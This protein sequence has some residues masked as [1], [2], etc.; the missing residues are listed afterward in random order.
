MQDD[1]VALMPGGKIYATENGCFAKTFGLNERDEPTIYHAVTSPHAYLEN[2]SQD[3]DGE[4]DFYDTSYTQNGSSYHP[5]N[6]FRPGLYIIPARG[7]D[8]T[9]LPA[10]RCV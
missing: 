9:N 7:S 3:A 8:E 6:T 10:I 5:L 4:L 1:F 2:V